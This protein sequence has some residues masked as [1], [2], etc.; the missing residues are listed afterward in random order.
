VKISWTILLFLFLQDLSAQIDSKWYEGKIQQQV[1]AVTEVLFHDVINPPAAARFYAYTILTGY[2]LASMNNKEMPSF[3]RKFKEYP[4]V[5]FH[6]S[7]DYDLSFAALYGMLETAKGI[8]PSGMKL[9]EKQQ[10]LL[11]EYGSVQH[12]K[13][14]RFIGGFGPPHSQGHDRL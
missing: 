12:Q 13:D 7:S 10:L 11:K 14:H 9:E 6:A 4:V 5:D 2:E 3:Q 1:Y 8:L